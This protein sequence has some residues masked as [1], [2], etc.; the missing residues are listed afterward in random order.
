[1]PFMN[2][3]SLDAFIVLNTCRPLV[4]SVLDE[5]VASSSMRYKLPSTDPPSP[6]T[7]SAFKPSKS[8]SKVSFY[9]LKSF[10]CS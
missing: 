5:G 6:Y 1:M 4:S 9:F 7:P 3:S 10:V 2:L 8:L